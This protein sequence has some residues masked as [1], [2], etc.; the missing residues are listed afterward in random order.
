[1]TKELSDS[2]FAVPVGFNSKRHMVIFVH[3]VPFAAK[4][5]EPW[6]RA[7]LLRLLPR[8]EY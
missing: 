5:T 7:A 1:M 3:F 4:P 2:N 6:R 8:R